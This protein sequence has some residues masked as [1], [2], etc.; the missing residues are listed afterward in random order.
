MSNEAKQVEEAPLW[1]RTRLREVAE[2]CV[3]T[4]RMLTALVEGVKR[5]SALAKFLFRKPWAV[6]PEASL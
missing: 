4:E 1:L 2:P 3:W 6:L 5:P